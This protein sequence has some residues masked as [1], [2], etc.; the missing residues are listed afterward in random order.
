MVLHDSTERGWTYTWYVVDDEQWAS[1]VAVF[2]SDTGDMP[3]TWARCCCSSCDKGNNLPIWDWSHV[4]N[5]LS[6]WDHVLWWNFIREEI[7]FSL[8]LTV[9]TKQEGSIWIYQQHEQLPGSCC[10]DCSNSLQQIYIIKCQLLYTHVY[11]LDFQVQFCLLFAEY[12][13]CNRKS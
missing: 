13:G 3:E 6:I 9:T 12:K 2:T 7:L 4:R 1:S 10:R 11:W 8:I 5:N